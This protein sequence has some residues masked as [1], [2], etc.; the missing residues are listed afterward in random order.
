MKKTLALLFLSFCVIANTTNQTTG[1]RRITPI[2]ETE[3]TITDDNWI[4]VTK[5]ER[6]GSNEIRIATMKRDLSNTNLI[7]VSFQSY[8]EPI[9]QECPEQNEPATQEKSKTWLWWLVTPAA[10]G[11]WFLL[12]SRK[13]WKNIK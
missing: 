12:R 6:N 9:I 10:V 4:K 5:R 11:M 3:P 1:F 13:T 7:F 2:S 8:T